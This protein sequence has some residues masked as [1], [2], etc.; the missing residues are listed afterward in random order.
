MSHH[1]DLQRRA[2]WLETH[3]SL[4]DGDRG[5]ALLEKWIGGLLQVLEGMALI[6]LLI[7]CANVANLLLV[8]TARRYGELAMRGAL[9]AS[10]RRIFQQVTT[11]GLLLGLCGAVAGLAL[12]W[13]SLQFVL[14]MIPE[15]NSLRNAMPTHMDWQVLLFCAGVGILTSILFS[16]APAFLSMRINLIRALHSQSGAMTSSGAK[17]RNGLVSAEIALSMTLLAAATVFGWTLYQLRNLD[18]GFI[19]DHL[20]TFSMDASALGK[21]E[22]E[23]RNEYESI[24]NEIRRQPGVR[25]VSFSR[26]GLIT[27]SENGDGIQVAGYP[28]NDSDPSPDDNWVSPGFFSTAQIPLLAGA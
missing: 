22:A 13:F 15:G 17:L 23:V 25:S 9:G 2:V 11:E 6:V 4:Q 27:G 26:Q 21:S 12:G 1:I 8:K 24:T 16:L 7:A 28:N 14:G 10:R 20:L 3:L 19:P 5:L 18:P